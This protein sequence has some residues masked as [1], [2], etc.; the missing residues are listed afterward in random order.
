M[1]IQETAALEDW[2]LAGSGSSSSCPKSRKECGLLGAR[3]LHAARSRSTVIRIA[4]SLAAPHHLETSSCR[5][6]EG[7]RL[8]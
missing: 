6:L 7:C 8:H 3:A 4:G 2:S 1:F 5:R